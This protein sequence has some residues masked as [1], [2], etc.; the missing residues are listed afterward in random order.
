MLV[1]IFKLVS[2]SIDQ[3]IHGLHSHFVDGI[4][5]PLILVTL[6]K[7]NNNPHTLR[8]HIK[9]RH[10]NPT[11]NGQH[12]SYYGGVQRKQGHAQISDR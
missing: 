4:R 1:Y 12:Y 6:E 5:A 10:N 8:K 3:Y 2:V 11:Y 9:R 7:K